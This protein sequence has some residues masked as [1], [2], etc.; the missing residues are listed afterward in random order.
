M[1]IN[2]LCTAREDIFQ[3]QWVPRR[4]TGAKSDSLKVGMPHLDSFESRSPFPKQ[5]TKFEDDDTV[6]KLEDETEDELYDGS[7]WIRL[8]HNHNSATLAQ[9]EPL[10]HPALA[11]SSSHR[12]PGTDA[13]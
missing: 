2:K 9:Y 13:V 12:E 6:L 8:L 11:T 5:R 1:M 7:D 10:K 3:G 4:G